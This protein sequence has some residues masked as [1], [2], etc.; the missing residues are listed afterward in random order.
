MFIHLGAV[1]GLHG[2]DALAER[3]EHDELVGAQHGPAGGA[4]M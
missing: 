4:K 1:A 2:D 3:R